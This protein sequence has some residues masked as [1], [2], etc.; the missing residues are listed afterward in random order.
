MTGSST[1]FPKKERLRKPDQIRSI[2][3][4]GSSVRKN[5]VVLYYLKK[6]TAR[7]NRFAVGISKQV[8]KRAV[9]RNR[10]KRI[11]REFFRRSKRSFK[12]DYDLLV[13]IKESG[14][15]LESNSLDN[16]LSGLFKQAGILPS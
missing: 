2:L 10:I 5:G 16:N 7:E 13:K 15:L 3:K 12:D 11:A 14:N 9:D 4:Y 1:S 6:D 8:F